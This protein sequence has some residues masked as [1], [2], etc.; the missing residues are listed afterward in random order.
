MLGHSGMQVRESDL[1]VGVWDAAET[2]RSLVRLMWGEDGEAAG[3]IGLAVK[4]PRQE[5]AGC[6]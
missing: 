6:W 3:R 1:A 2:G 5:G 4:K